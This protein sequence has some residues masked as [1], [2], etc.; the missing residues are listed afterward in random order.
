M[1][2]AGHAMMR[3][4]WDACG[5]SPA[6]VDLPQVYDGFSP[7]VFFWLELLGICAP[8]EAHQFVLAGGIDGDAPDGLP[9]LTSGGALGNGRMH[10][11]PQ[12]LECYLQLSGRAAERQR[13]AS[14]AV[15]CQGTPQY[16]GAVVYSADPF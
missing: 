3:H 8:G 4:L 6:D 9:V 16:S 5:L 12:M 10:G 14:I 11:V 1:M 15:A 2:D 7:L 13:D